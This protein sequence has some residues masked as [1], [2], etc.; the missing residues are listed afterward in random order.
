MCCHGGGGVS[1]FTG[2]LALRRN[3]LSQPLGIDEPLWL[4]LVGERGTGKVRLRVPENVG[5][6][7]ATYMVQILS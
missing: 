5:L 3:E 1:L 2:A 4:E 6:L 7:W